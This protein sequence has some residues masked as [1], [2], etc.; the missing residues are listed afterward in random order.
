MTRC[1]HRE[2][3]DR[4]V[5][6]ARIGRRGPR[7][8]QRGWGP[9]G[10]AGAA[11]LLCLP[12]LLGACERQRSAPA[13]GDS[14]RPGERGIAPAEAD[15]VEDE[16]EAAPPV[17]EHA[18]EEPR[19]PSYA[20]T[21]YGFRLSV[22]DDW[23]FAR[24]GRAILP[25]GP[26]EAAVF[27][28]PAVW[29]ELEGTDIRNAVSVKAIALL[30]ACDVEEFADKYALSESNGRVSIEPVAGFA[31]PAYVEVVEWRGLTYKRRLEFE[32]RHGIG[33]VIEF[34]ATPGTFDQNYPR[35]RSVADQVEF[36][37]PVIDEA[38]EAP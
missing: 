33:Y 31:R 23:E 14:T 8:L 5:T 34:T 32:R 9:V 26:S 1:G 2:P 7:L 19:T 12:V 35:F 16:N 36:M 37:P 4:S 10:L 24:E 30:E 15:V 22:P 13:N 20:N 18:A 6:R 25:L 29:S 11:A 28:L 3:A 38:D 21:R 17:D 27:A